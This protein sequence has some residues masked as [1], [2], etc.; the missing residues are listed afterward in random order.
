MKDDIEHRTKA[1]SD[2][3]SAEKAVELKRTIVSII[4]IYIRNIILDSN[5]L[6]TAGRVARLIIDASKG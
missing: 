5:R 3:K 6:P 4:T 2:I 1:I